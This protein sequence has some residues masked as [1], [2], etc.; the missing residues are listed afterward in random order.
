MEELDYKSMQ[1]AKAREDAEREA[2]FMSDLGQANA[3]RKKS[4]Q[5]FADRLQKLAAR[6]KD[7]RRKEMEQ[8]QEKAAQEAREAIRSRAEKQSTETW[9]ESPKAKSMREMLNKMR[10]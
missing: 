5:A 4:E 9:N 8:E 10:G 1:E 2:K 3:A 7:L 6:E